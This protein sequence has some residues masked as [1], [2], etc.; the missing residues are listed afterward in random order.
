[1]SVRQFLTP[2]WKTFYSRAFYNTAAGGHVRALVFL[3]VLC[4]VCAAAS[5]VKLHLSLAAGMKDEVS[6]LIAQI[7]EIHI[8]G[9]RLTTVQLPGSP[10]VKEPLYAIR[11]KNGELL[12]VIDET[13]GSAPE[14]LGGAKLYLTGGE[15]SVSNAMPG[16][17]SFSHL[18][19]LVVDRETLMGW[20]LKAYY[21]AGLAVFP[22]LIVGVVLYRF[23]QAAL[24]SL[25]AYLVLLALKRRRPFPFC[26]ALASYSL[27]PPVIIGTVIDLSTGVDY[28]GFLL[29]LLIAALIIVLAVRTP[30]EKK[31]L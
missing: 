19:D 1:M 14:G 17:Y 31:V 2:L 15:A 6:F 21:L 29:T 25:F 3:F 28:I 11:A 18:H 7:P 4:L 24:L 27:I 26:L 23:A 9:G 20:A 10:A 13:A 12:A 22:L 8:S 30:D 5:S 16:S